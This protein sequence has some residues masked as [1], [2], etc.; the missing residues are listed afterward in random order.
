MVGLLRRGRVNSRLEDDI[1]DPFK[2]IK[3]YM[4]LCESSLSSSPAFN[5][6]GSCDEL[7]VFIAPQSLCSQ[8]RPIVEDRSV[9]T[10]AQVD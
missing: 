2:E 6:I 10:P 9:H 3:A 1:G 5:E 4:G 7:P 8:S